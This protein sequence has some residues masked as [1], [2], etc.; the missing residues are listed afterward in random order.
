MSSYPRCHVGDILSPPFSFTHCMIVGGGEVETQWAGMLQAHGI[1]VLAFIASV[2]DLHIH[3]ADGSGRSLEALVEAGIDKSIPI[4][5]CK[6]P[7]RKGMTWSLLKSAMAQQGF[8]RFI[9][10]EDLF[11]PRGQW[12]DEVS[13]EMPIFSDNMRFWMVE[14]LGFDP[15]Q[16]EAAIEFGLTQARALEVGCCGCGPADF[17]MLHWSVHIM[18]AALLHLDPGPVVEVGTYVGGLTCSLGTAAK[19]LGQSLTAFEIGSAYMEHSNLPTADIIGDLR[20]NIAA[21]HLQDCVSL[22]MEKAECVD[23]FPGSMKK[24]PIKILVIDADGDVVNKIEALLPYLA[25]GCILIVDDFV[26]TGPASM[27]KS[28]STRREVYGLVVAG[29]AEEMDVIGWGTW[30]GRIVSPEKIS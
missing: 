30:F 7:S 16:A 27:R 14:R 22:V 1:K 21:Y 19:A 3:A 17:S 29:L 8:Q 15:D 18:A 13:E 23:A 5:L 20:A 11:F 28:Y 26:M 25:P 9:F 6:T 10:F 4:I 24:S 2:G 12:T